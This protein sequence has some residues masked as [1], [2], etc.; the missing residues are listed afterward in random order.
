M[1]GGEAGHIV[2]LIDSW[3][4]R[5]EALASEIHADP[6]LAWKEVHAAEALAS[7]CETLGLEVT[8]SAYGLDTAF[9]AEGGA[10]PGAGPR[11]VFCSEYDALPG[12]GHACGHNLIGVI[13]AAAGAAL[14]AVCTPLGGRSVVLGT[15]AE[16]AG[17]G[18]VVL[19]DRGAFTGATCSMMVHPATIDAEWT[20]MMA[21]SEVDVVYRGK[22]AHAAVSP[23][24]GINALDALVTAYQSIGNLRQHIRATERIHG[25][26]T[27][28][29]KAPNIVPDRAAG[30]FYVRAATA[31]ALDDL[32]RRVQG[33]FDAGVAATGA[34]LETEWHPPYLEVTPNVPLAAVYR[35]HAEA[36]GRRMLDPFSLPRHATG[37]TD[38]GNVSYAV[39]SIHPVLAVAP[40]GVPPHSAEFAHYTD[41]DEAREAMVAAAKAL[42]LTGLDVMADEGLRRS[43]KEWFDSGDRPWSVRAATPGM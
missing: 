42:A 13:S 40:P 30:Q 24:A 27:D 43:M 32:R 21:I 4:P 17:G 23:H 10:A 8:R 2:E 9:E 28:G 22:A 38:M 1:A 36:L 26:I 14:A 16:E 20:P 7:F 29:G 11:V 41:T 31:G 5:M 34:A 15:P 19:L 18:K 35:A 39:P 6:E 33:C 3:R 25:I 37:S 12:I